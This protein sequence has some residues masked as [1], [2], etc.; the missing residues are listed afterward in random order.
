METRQMTPFLSTFSALFVT[1]IFI[2]ENGQDSFSYGLPFG[3]FWSLKCLNFGQK[4]SIR[5]AH[6]IFLESR[7]SEVTKNP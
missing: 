4:L 2:F 1:F 6:H 3:L 7:H 5:T